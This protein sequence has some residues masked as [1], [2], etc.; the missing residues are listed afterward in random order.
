MRLIN[1]CFE[2]LDEALSQRRLEVFNADRAVKFTAEAFIG[3]WNRPGWLGVNDYQ[4]GSY[5]W[6]LLQ[7]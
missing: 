5:R 1:Q 2:L 4:P 6:P 7:F 3:R